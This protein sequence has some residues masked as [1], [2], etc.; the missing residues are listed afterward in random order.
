MPQRV[1]PVCPTPPTPGPGKKELDRSIQD[2]Q[3]SFA[4]RTRFGS[5]FDFGNSVRPGGQYDYKLRIKGS[6]SFGNFAYG[7]TGRAQGYSLGKLQTMA[8]LVQALT[9]YEI[10][11]LM[12][13]A[14][15][16]VTQM[17]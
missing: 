11:T 2:S 8:T 10:W 9:I 17:K 6:A 15:I 7:A 16:Q 13:S 5:A 1:Q 12:G 3:R 14:T 4:E